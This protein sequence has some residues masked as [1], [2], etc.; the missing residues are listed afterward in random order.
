MIHKQHTE[1]SGGSHHQIPHFPVHL[2]S[3]TYGS[4]YTETA[5][6]EL[7]HLENRLVRITI[8]ISFHFDKLYA[9]RS[10]TLMAL[11]PSKYVKLGRTTKDGS[12]TAMG[13]IRIR[14]SHLLG[15]YQVAF[16]V[17]LKK[18]YL[19]SGEFANM[20]CGV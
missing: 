12:D 1:G 15:K 19:T 10:Q 6:V 7:L 14:L 8:A 3:Q 11:Y 18:R 20:Y 2:C 16:S 13:N 5:E 9:S 17:C 4:V